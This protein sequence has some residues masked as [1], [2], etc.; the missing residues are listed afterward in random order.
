MAGLAI[1]VI[2]DREHLSPKQVRELLI[3]G[4]PGVPPDIQAFII[5][6]LKP[7]PLR[8][9]SRLAFFRRRQ[10]IHPALDI[11]P[12]RI[13]EFLERGYPHHDSNTP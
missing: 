8:R 4:A 1:E 5:A 9:F 12:Q 2:S 11:D 3:N 10:I 6:G 13:V 7:E